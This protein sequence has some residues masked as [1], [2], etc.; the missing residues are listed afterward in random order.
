ML[1]D[2]TYEEIA[3]VLDTWDEAR[4][5]STGNFDANFGMVAL[6]KLFDLQPSAKKVF[7][8][9]KG[10]TVGSCQ[11]QI[12][13]N[14]FTVLF[15]SVFQMLGPDVEFI[16]DILAQVGE[17]HKGMGVCPSFFPFMGQALIHALES[18]LP[19]KLTEEQRDAWENVYDAVSN[20]IVKQI[21]Q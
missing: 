17:R 1:A 12:H 9:D 4:L 16:Q 11:A 13:A 19:S 10:E 2:L 21:L 15:D 5:S 8:Y 14:A 6:E 3:L 18:F 20:E 7:G